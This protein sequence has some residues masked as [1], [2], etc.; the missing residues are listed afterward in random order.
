MAIN[1]ISGS[2]AGMAHIQVQTDQ[3]V[4]NEAVAQNVQNEQIAVE[5]KVQEAYKIEEQLVVNN[6]DLGSGGTSPNLNQSG[7]ASFSFLA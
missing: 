2:A 4:S 3:S 1:G 6:I 7:Q 5:P